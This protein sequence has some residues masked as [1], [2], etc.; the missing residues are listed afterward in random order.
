MSGL[1]AIAAIGALRGAVEA[2]PRILR[3]R[4]VLP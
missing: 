4:G 2:A 3:K 1:L